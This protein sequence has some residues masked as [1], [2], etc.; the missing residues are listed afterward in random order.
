MDTNVGSVISAVGWLKELFPIM[1]Y[2]APISAPIFC[3]V[4]PSTWLRLNKCLFSSALLVVS[5]DSIWTVSTGARCIL[6]AYAATSPNQFNPSSSSNWR[7]AKG[8]IPTP[9]PV[10]PST[11]GKTIQTNT[12]QNKWHELTIWFHSFF[13]KPNWPCHKLEGGPQ[14]ATQPTLTTIN[15]ERL[16]FAFIIVSRSQLSIN[17]WRWIRTHSRIR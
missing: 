6:N 4:V 5:D 1:I 13:S 12:A 15:E 11:T 7:F 10:V 8:I 9:F 14:K 17:I 16:D 2:F 3:A